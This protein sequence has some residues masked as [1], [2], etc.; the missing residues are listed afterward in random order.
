MPEPLVTVGTYST[1]YEA[2]LVRSE[3]EAF[4]IDAVLADDHAITLNWLWS[5]AMG[6]V[7]VRVPESATEQARRIM[8]LEPGEGADPAESALVCPACGSH[9]SHYFS[10]KRGTFLTWLLVGV[11][12]VPVLA[13]RVCDDC[14]SKWKP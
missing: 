10:D 2:N 14:G 8:G 1:A 3:L 12:L 11:P 7:K 13:R 4:E 5:N 9:R 6:G